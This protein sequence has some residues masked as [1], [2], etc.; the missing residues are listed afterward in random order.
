DRRHRHVVRWHALVRHCR[1]FGADR[2]V[3]ETGSLSPASPWAPHPPNRTDAAWTELQLIVREALRVAA[4]HGV[5]LLLKPGG[6]HVLA[7]AADALG[8][9]A[10]LDAP[11]LAFVLDP[12][13]FLLDCLPEDLGQEVVRLADALGP[14]APVV[15]AK[16][17]RPDAGHAATPRAGRGLLDY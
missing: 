7:T 12:A 17:L 4:D 15:H 11:R 6:A 5:T 14:F 8:L 10:A 2:V 13:T 1:D 3:T 16:D 9:R